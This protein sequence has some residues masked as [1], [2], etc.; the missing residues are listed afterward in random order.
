M[1]NKKYLSLVLAS[2]I[3]TS[4]N[5]KKA[6]SSSEKADTSTAETTSVTETTEAVTETAEPIAEKAETVMSKG[7]GGS[8][9][10][11]I[12]K[13][14]THCYLCMC[15]G[16]EDLQE[17]LDKI[18]SDTLRE[19]VRSWIEEN[20]TVMNEKYELLQKIAEKGKTFSS[21]YYEPCLT[22]YYQNGYLIVNIT[23]GAGK[24]FDYDSEY[25]YYSQTE[26][27]NAIGIF[28]CITEKQL[29]MPELFYDDV[30]Y[31]AEANEKFEEALSVPY[32]IDGFSA[33]YL[34]QKRPFSGFTDDMLTFDGRSFC[35]NYGN[36][37]ISTGIS[38]YASDKLLSENCVLWHYREPNGE[39]NAE[40]DTYDTYWTDE[41]FESKKCG[42]Y[43][44][45][46][47]ES[48]IK[49]SK[50]WE[51]EKINKINEFAMD[52]LY[53]E[54]FENN[55]SEIFELTLDSP[56]KDEEGYFNGVFFDVEP[57]AERNVF[58]IGVHS[59][60]G[61]D[62]A[63]G[64]EYI[65]DADT[66]ERL[67]N[68]EVMKLYCSEDFAEK[69]DF[70]YEGYND[71]GEYENLT[72]TVNYDEVISSLDGLYLNYASGFSSG[73]NVTFLVEKTEDKYYGY[74]TYHFYYNENEDE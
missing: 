28:D 11:E 34:E 57:D 7:C 59:A 12:S 18:V 53:S 13:Q 65:Y 64:Y 32:N 31:L 55:L 66:F 70:Y 45:V 41:E 47:L 23:L 56:L 52:F 37:F 49:S 19:K 67:S 40:I 2:M 26:F 15:T 3:L 46:E 63:R 71:N 21:E 17:A 74:S 22:I 38:L 58:K 69:A 36:P 20:R 24:K 44:N 54:E 48:L 10:D 61:A 29:T 5:T 72:D 62:Y 25:E 68:T 43:H 42:M 35:L 33:A 8:R 73:A 4:C 16:Y 39:I 30:D 9:P 50:V 1:K 51:D 60:H 27:A 6:D 14:Y